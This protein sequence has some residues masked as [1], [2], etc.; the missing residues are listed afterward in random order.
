MFIATSG[1]IT[2]KQF[3]FRINKMMRCLPESHWR[4]KYC[5][6]IKIYWVESL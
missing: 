2:F 3:G 5:W 6:H 4:T 1:F